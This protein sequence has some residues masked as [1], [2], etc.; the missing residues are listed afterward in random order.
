MLLSAL[1][2]YDPNP[3][4]T[5]EEWRFCCPLSEECRNKP[6]DKQHQSL[7]VRKDDLVGHCFRCSESMRCDERGVLKEFRK[8][9]RV[10]AMQH[11]YHKRMGIFE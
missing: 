10:S 3:T 6:V 9:A 1:Y 2:A 5:G 8:H 7:T 4:D 11:A